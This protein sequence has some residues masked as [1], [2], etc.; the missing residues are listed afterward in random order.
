MYLADPIWD[1]ALNLYYRGKDIH[2]MN[3]YQKIALIVGAVALLIVYGKT[4]TKVVLGLM[5]F[6][7][8]GII[9]V[10]ATLLIYYTLKR[11]RKEKK[12]D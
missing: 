5:A 12:N 2:N 6:M 4:M 9:I 8:K 11:K 3:K 7:G 10:G 1:K